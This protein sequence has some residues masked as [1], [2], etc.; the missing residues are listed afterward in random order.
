MTFRAMFPYPRSHALRGNGLPGR[1][2]SRRLCERA[3][4]DR[5]PRDAERRK[6]R[7]PTQSVG[8]RVLSSC[9]GFVDGLPSPAGVVTL[10]AGGGGGGAAG[11][12]AG[13]STIASGV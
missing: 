2:A 13:G 1:S 12:G 9:H 6:Q 10:S 8:T 4:P 3:L 11:G 5:V 7:V